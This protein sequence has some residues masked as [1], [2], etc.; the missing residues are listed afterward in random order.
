MNSAH[1]ENDPLFQRA[2]DNLIRDLS[3][4][5][6]PEM[7]RRVL[8]NPVGWITEGRMILTEAGVEVVLMIRVQKIS[9]DSTERVAK[10]EGRYHV[11]G[12]DAYSAQEG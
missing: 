11:F 8:L 3:E 2:R 6:I 7:A 9:A 10:G 4:A 1:D 12:K 5:V